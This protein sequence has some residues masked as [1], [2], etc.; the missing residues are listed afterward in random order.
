MRRKP[1]DEAAL[2][3]A[4]DARGRRGRVSVE[5]LG[6]LEQIRL[7]SATPAHPCG[8]LVARATHKSRSV[9]AP[10]RGKIA[11]ARHFPEFGS[12]RAL[13]PLSLGVGA[14]KGSDGRRPADV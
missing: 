10:S 9:G 6:P 8:R 13:L 5:L 4:V 2:G 3:R 7:A 1:R 11:A 12:P 14:R